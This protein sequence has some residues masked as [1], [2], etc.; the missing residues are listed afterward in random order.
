MPQNSA[1]VR[2]GFA[3]RLRGGTVEP[4]V[5]RYGTKRH[6]LA[7]ERAGNSELVVVGIF[8]D[9]TLARCLQVLLESHQIQEESIA[10]AAQH[11]T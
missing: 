6:H 1:A 4:L 10:L 7:A 5:S 11:W 8:I 3:G 9:L 2:A